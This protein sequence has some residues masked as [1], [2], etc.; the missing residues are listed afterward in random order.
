MNGKSFLVTN[1]NRVKSTILLEVI[2][3]KRKKLKGK[4]KKIFLVTLF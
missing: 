2:R 4:N 1:L 3:E